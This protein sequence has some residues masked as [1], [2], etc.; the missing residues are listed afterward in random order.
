MIIIG[1]SARFICKKCGEGL[2]IA[3]TGGVNSRFHTCDE[4]TCEN[5]GRPFRILPARP[6]TKQDLEF[7][8]GMNILWEE[9][10]KNVGV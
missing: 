3:E 9:E 5:W 8:K 4:I 10:V 1:V 7:L 2:K 6:V